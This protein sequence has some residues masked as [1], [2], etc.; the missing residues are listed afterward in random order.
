LD[1]DGNIDRD[2]QNLLKEN[3]KQRLMTEKGF[4]E[5]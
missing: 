3:E 4:T 1:G 5:V 2:A